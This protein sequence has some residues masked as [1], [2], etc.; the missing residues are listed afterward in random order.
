MTTVGSNSLA[1]VREG[2]DPG[3][4]LAAQLIDAALH[5]G[6]GAA[7][8][9][10]YYVL[11]LLSPL[12]GGLVGFSLPL[13]VLAYQWQMLASEGQTVGKRAMGLRIVNAGDGGNPGFVK[14]IVM[15]NWLN[16]LFCAVGFYP[17]INVAPIFWKPRRC[18]HDYLAGTL[19]VKDDGSA[20]RAPGGSSDEF[21]V[22]IGGMERELAA[23][24]SS[25]VDAMV[26]LRKE[27]AKLQTLK[28]AAA[29][30]ETQAKEAV[31][32]GADE[33]ARQC[34]H[35]HRLKLEELA[36]HTR[37]LEEMSRSVASLKASVDAQAAKLATARAR[38]G[39]LKGRVALL[40]ASPSFSK[41]DAEVSKIEEKVGDQEIMADV[42]LDMQASPGS[43]AKPK[44]PP[45]DSIDDELEKLRREIGA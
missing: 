33:L 24:K 15:R 26:V 2:A 11:G 35:A 9:A 7:G 12:L 1:T 43:D 34:L 23:S 14:A 42:Q 3:E 28:A 6:S 4:R 31:Q 20:A 18:I 30:L 19:V 27:Q 17:L 25:L 16:K 37:H 10:A 41:F 38:K 40:E 13:A 32:R 21:E 8:V 5:L 45:A 29:R 22:L 39:S 44:L 36:A